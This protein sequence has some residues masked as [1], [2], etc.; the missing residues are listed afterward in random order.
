MTPER[1]HRIGQLYHEALQV[2]PERRA[3]FLENRCSGDA[4][5]REEVERMLTSHERMG[6]FLSRPAIDVAAGELPDKQIGDPHTFLTSLGGKSGDLAEQEIGHSHALSWLGAGGM[7]QVWL[8]RDTRLRRKV[9]LK[10]L[11][12][13]FMD[14]PNRVR[15]FIQEAQAASAL[16]HPNIITIY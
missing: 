9:A 7:G 1:Y 13:E 16:N 4:A 11:P 15:R 5:L 14:D 3:A 12:A 2:E 6:S 10:L 8:A